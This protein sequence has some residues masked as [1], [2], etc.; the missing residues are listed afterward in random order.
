MGESE[1]AEEKVVVIEYI[2]IVEVRYY[3]IIY[4]GTCTDAK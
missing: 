4:S 2:L 1:L 3:A